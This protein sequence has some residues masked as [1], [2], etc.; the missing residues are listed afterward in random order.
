MNEAPKRDISC[1]IQIFFQDSITKQKL[2]KGL[3][4]ENICLRWAD[5]SRRW[6]WRYYFYVKS[7]HLAFA[8][9]NK[10]ITDKVYWLCTPFQVVLWFEFW[11]RP[12]L[13]VHIL[14]VFLLDHMKHIKSYNRLWLWFGFVSIEWTKS[15]IFA[16][17]NT[18]VIHMTIIGLYL[19][20]N[21]GVHWWVFNLLKVCVAHSL[22]I[23]TQHFVCDFIIWKWKML[24]QMNQH[25]LNW[26][27]WY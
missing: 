4:L 15:I 13:Q 5:N 3:V 10:L 26:I 16:S 25:W 2:R 9:D 7:F 8:F 6:W 19:N 17:T 14:Y 24:N 11:H 21:V 22:H 12:K 23:Q 20:L 18:R 1:I 27:G